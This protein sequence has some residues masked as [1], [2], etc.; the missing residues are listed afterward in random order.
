ME[1]TPKME[2]PRG[3]MEEMGNDCGFLLVE[4]KNL[5]KRTFEGRAEAHLSNQNLR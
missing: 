5:G 3:I 1:I 2:V 4:S